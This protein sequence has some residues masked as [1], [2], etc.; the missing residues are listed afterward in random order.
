MKS[1]FRLNYNYCQ[2]N[3]FRILLIEI[4]YDFE[5]V[6]DNI[7]NSTEFIILMS[8]IKLKLFF[9]HYIYKIPKVLRE[10]II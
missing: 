9:F 4:I 1:F 5:N 2:M 8:E 10:I 6:I 7:A 3:K